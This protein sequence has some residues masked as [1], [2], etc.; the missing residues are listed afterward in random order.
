MGELG[1]KLSSDDKSAIQ[2]D[3][4]KVKEALKGTDSGM[5]KLAADNLSKKFGEISSKLYQ[6]SGAPNMGDMGGANPNM[7]GQGSGG[8]QGD[9]VDADFTEINDDENK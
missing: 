4:D 1:G 3:I 6:Q 2:S 5:I 8:S 9:F 7:G